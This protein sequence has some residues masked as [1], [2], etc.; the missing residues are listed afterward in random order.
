MNRGVL[1][2]IV[3]RIL[4]S[5]LVLWVIVTIL[6]LLFRL[7]PAN[8]MASY[9]DIT[10]T[11]EQQAALMA[12][13]GLDRPLGEQYIIY[14][15]NL[16]RGDLGETFKYAGKSVVD[17]LREDLP[18]TVYLTLT[19]LLLAYLVG[20][21][22]GVILAARR[23]SGFEKGGIVF[24]LLTRSAP[25]FWVGMIVLA[26]FAFRLRWFPSSG[27]GGAGTIYSSEWEKL[28]SPEFWRHMVLPTFTLTLYLMGLPLLLMRSNMLEVLDQDY[29]T[30]SRL[31]G[32]S[33][34]RVMI[35]T[36]ARNAMLP[37]LTALTLGIGYSIGGNVVIEHVFAWPG[38]GRTLIRAVQQADY[39]LAQGAFFLIAVI[40]VTLNFFADM[41]YTLLDPR[42]GASSR[43]QL[44]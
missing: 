13:F 35:Q 17:I 24:T 23:G 34:W 43:A 22:G 19:S 37:V 20:T 28:S 1:A 3:G 4:Q 2:Y 8:P 16:L 14:L 21:I 26:I 11:A 10:F 39:P 6:F 12:R 25:Q 5:L 9:I 33:E 32:Y 29:V 36:A 31:A 30:M 18:N 15:G 38:L 27:V 7:G 40:I 41:L 44:S 42:I